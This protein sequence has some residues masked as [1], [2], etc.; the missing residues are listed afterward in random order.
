MARHTNAAG[1]AP[2]V[3]AERRRMLES[4]GY[5]GGNGGAEKS[6]AA[7]PKDKLA[8]YNLYEKSL[9]AMYAGHPREA[10][11]SFRQLLAADPHNSL[12]RYYLGDACLRAGQSEAAL[13]EWDTALQIDPEYAPA[14]EALGAWW[15]GRENYAK[16]RAYFQKALA[17]AP[18]DSTAL[19]EEG[20]AEE[21]LGLRQ[22]ALRHIEDACK[23]APGLP[24]CA[25]ELE[26]ARQQAK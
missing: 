12:A 18:R 11:A 25:R 4:L 8:E 2:A 16:A 19:L 9:A 13:R 17:A 5:L 24:R 1:T 26:A 10:I 21:R 22:E 20:I 23:L 14:A 3:S 7:D 15:M 6:T